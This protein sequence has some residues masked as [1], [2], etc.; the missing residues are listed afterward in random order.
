MY[1]LVARIRPQ[2]PDPVRTTLVAT[3][4]LIGGVDQFK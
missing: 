2:Q 4:A 3:Q 1:H